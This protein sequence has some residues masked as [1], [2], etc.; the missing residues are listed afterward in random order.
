[1]CAT[2]SRIKPKTAGAYCSDEIELGIKY[3]GGSAPISS[4]T[5][6]DTQNNILIKRFYDFNGAFVMSEKIPLDG[7]TNQRAYWSPNDKKLT[8]NDLSQAWDQLYRPKSEWLTIR[9]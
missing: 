6:H 3:G 4:F 8:E 5:E 9:K 7:N 1:M 2:L